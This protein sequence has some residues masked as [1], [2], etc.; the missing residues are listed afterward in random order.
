MNFAHTEL[1]RRKKLANFILSLLMAAL[2]AACAG[3]DSGSDKREPDKTF[4]PTAVDDFDVNGDINRDAAHATAIR[5]NRTYKG[6]IFPQG[7]LDWV[8]LDLKA[9]TTYEVVVDHQCPTCGTETR[10]YGTDGVTEVGARNNFYLAANRIKFTPAASGTYFLKIGYQT[11]DNRQDWGVSN[12][13]L[14]V[15][16]YV[17]SDGDDVSSWF[18]CNEKN[19]DISIWGNDIP[20]DGVDQDCTGA[21]MLLASDPD[22]FEPTD[23][24][25]AT[26]TSRIPMANYQLY[27]LQYLH[28]VPEDRWGHSLTTGDA[29]WFKVTVPAGHYYGV[30][31]LMADGFWHEEVYLEDGVT[32]SSLKNS[33][34]SDQNV[35][36]K[37]VSDGGH[38]YLPL[39]I[40]YG[41]DNDG[42]GYYSQEQDIFRDCDDNNVAINPAAAEISGNS[43]NED[44][45]YSLSD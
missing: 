15:H 22:S 3:G 34:S 41:T 44:C 2:L 11:L 30:T 45:R 43:I 7:D 16:S 35:L 39:M 1:I 17:D 25:A 19:A 12:Y 10:M 13:W 37:I 21:D 14:N 38:F 32:P 42:D 36:V 27:Q 6:T 31:A 20:G 23:N 40:D 8:K 4:Y 33:S 9:G 26:T 24:N 18:D 29:D 28:M 5:V